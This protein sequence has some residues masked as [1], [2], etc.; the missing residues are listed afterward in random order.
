VP[1]RSTHL[2]DWLRFNMRRTPTRTSPWLVYA[3]Q[4]LT[5]QLVQAACYHPNGI[6]NTQP[7]HAPCS[8]DALNPLSTIC[9]ATE[10]PNPAG[11]LIEDG[12]TNDICLENGICMNQYQKNRTDPKIYS[13]YFREEC[14]VQNWQSG[15]CLTVCVDD[16]RLS[17]LCWACENMRTGV[18]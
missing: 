15:K 13:E 3:L 6:Q 5:P 12:F 4:L 16:V 2:R 7:H 11:G 18:D 1:T 9:C 8:N 10:R 17:V 14:T